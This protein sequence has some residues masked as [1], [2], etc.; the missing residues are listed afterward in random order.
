M[1]KIPDELERRLDALERNNPDEAEDIMRGC[2]FEM[3]YCPSSVAHY[4]TMLQDD[5]E[6][7]RARIV[8]ITIKPAPKTPEVQ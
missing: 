3:G 8:G 6:T 5:G 7:F 1:A 2:V 4:C